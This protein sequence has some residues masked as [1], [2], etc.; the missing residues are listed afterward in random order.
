MRGS[1]ISMS[2]S[3]GVISMFLMSWTLLLLML[4]LVMMHG[5]KFVAFSNAA[6]KFSGR[7]WLNLPVISSQVLHQ[8][9]SSPYSLLA[10][11]CSLLVFVVYCCCFCLLIWFWWLW[12]KLCWE[13]CESVPLNRTGSYVLLWQSIYNKNTCLCY[14]CKVFIVES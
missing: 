6:C 4:C 5:S 12:H 11:D 8:F 14:K 2:S 3:P 9:M 7:S 1:F 13:C 10:T